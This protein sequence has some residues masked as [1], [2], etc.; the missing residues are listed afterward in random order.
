MIAGCH[1]HIAKQDE[2]AVGNQ[3]TLNDMLALLRDASMAPGKSLLFWYIA[4]TDRQL[5]YQLLMGQMWH[6]LFPIDL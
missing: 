4:E 2:H 1:A 6:R 3:S 5:L